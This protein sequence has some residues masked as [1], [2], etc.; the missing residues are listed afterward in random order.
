M[1][2]DSVQHLDCWSV[3]CIS[4]RPYTELIQRS[5]TASLVLQMVNSLLKTVN[6]DDVAATTINPNDVAT[7]AMNLDDVAAVKSLYKSTNG[8]NRRVQTGWMKGDPC[9]SQLHGIMW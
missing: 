9:S 7:I 3:L 2:C 1:R 6:P 8:S 5:P 4:T